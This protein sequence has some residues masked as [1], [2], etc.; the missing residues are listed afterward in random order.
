MTDTKSARNNPVPQARGLEVSNEIRESQN[1]PPV[2][3]FHMQYVHERALGRF[4][5]DLSSTYI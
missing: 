5:D 2:D 3:Y 4:F 1:L